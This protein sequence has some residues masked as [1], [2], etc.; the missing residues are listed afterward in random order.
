MKT[1]VISTRVPEAFAK[2]LSAYCRHNGMTI[3]EYMQ[4]GF[5]KVGMTELGEI[6]IESDT[7]EMLVSLGVGSMIGILSYKGVYGVLT[8]KG[9]TKEQAEF[10]ALLSAITCSLLSGYGVNKLMKALR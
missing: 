9:Y 6:K 4:Q 5:S 1:K 10:F 3:S 2:E 8:Q 7:K